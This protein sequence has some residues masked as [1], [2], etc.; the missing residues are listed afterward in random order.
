MNK[1]EFKF[2]VN[3]LYRIVH[4]LKMQE[5]VNKYTRLYDELNAAED[6]LIKAMYNQDQ[7]EYE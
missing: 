2:K 5:G 6:H 7:Y 4:L 3:E 1:E